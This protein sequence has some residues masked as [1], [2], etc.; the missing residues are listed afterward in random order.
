MGQAKIKKNRA[1]SQRYQ[2][3]LSGWEARFCRLAIA[4]R[5]FKALAGGVLGPLIFMFWLMPGTCF[6]ENKWPWEL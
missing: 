3:A 5:C 2:A 1:E 6:T 4:K